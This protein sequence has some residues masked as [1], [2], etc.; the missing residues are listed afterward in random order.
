MGLET[1]SS[2]VVGIVALVSLTLSILT[3]EAYRRM[4]NRKILF[5][6]GAF[7]VH[8]VKSAFVAVAIYG[9][10]VGHEALEIVEAVFDLAM[11][12]LLFIPFW[13]RG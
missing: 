2:A 12:L 11:V 5:V 6:A 7:M 1:Y 8:F 4:Q 9:R 13:T 3:F 10:L